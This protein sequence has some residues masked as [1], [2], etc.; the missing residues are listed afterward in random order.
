M[1]LVS[2]TWSNKLY[3]NKMNSL[4]RSIYIYASKRIKASTVTSQWG[5]RENKEN[6]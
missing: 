6:K 5:E 4:L 2:K 1:N 3:G